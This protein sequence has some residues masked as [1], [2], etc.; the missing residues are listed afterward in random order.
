MGGSGRE[1]GISKYFHRSIWRS[2]PGAPPPRAPPPQKLLTEQ[3]LRLVCS[4]LAGEGGQGGAL[5]GHQLPPV[6]GGRPLR[7][8]PVSG[9]IKVYPSTQ[10]HS[11]SSPSSCLLLLLLLLSENELPSY[12]LAEEKV[13]SAPALPLIPHSFNVS[14][15]G[16]AFISFLLP[17]L[18]LKHTE[19]ERTTKWLKMLKSW[20]KYKNSEKVGCSSHILELFSNWQFRSGD[21]TV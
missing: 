9:E 14:P 12:D 19:V 15:G 21:R 7:L 2:E 1:E 18:Q 10:R 16:G 6:Q 11:S 5:G 17:V 20:D 8:R 3:R 13:S 4:G